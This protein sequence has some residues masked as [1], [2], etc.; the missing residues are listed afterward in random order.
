MK[1]IRVLHVVGNMHAGGLE[2]LIMNWY[3]SVDRNLVQFDFLTNTNKPGFYDKE[4][5]E[6][7]GRIYRLS[8]MDDKN[9]IKYIKDLRCF[10]ITHK[11]FS[12]V[13]GHHSALG[14]FYLRA[15]K[16]AGVKCRI[17]HS[18]TSSHSNN[19]RGLLKHLIMR[20]FGKYATHQFA[21]SIAAGDYMY[22][23]RGKYRVINNGV[24]TEKFAFSNIVRESKR[25]ELRIEDKLVLVH[26]GRFD[27]PKNHTYLIDIFN[28]IKRNR[29]KAILLLVGE[30][31]LMQSIQEKV[32]RLDLE[33]DV[34]FLGTRMDVNE[35]LCAADVM[36]FPSLWEGLP[37]TLVEAQASGLPIVC[38][39]NVTEET[40]LTENY[41]VLSLEESVTKWAEEIIRA[42]EREH[43]RFGMNR[44]VREKKY[45]SYDVAREMQKF[46]L[47]Q[48][49]KN[50]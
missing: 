42:T 14:L 45:D 4:I 30:G 11:E 20:G 50:N 15:A 37:L 7:G 39:K 19:M 5:L 28:E 35:I 32:K 16:Q 31:P 17:S 8:F 29:K 34:C 41:K 47:E 33:D 18:H 49:E 23:K 2:T 44:V 36:V 9:I 13:H 22:G 24:N 46:Y 38:S 40:R 48:T 12:I 10:F 25:A 43:V 27:E 26:V 6:L 21:C 1:P 3:R